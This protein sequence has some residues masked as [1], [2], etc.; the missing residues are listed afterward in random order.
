M[1]IKA[2]QNIPKNELVMDKIIIDKL[3][4]QFIGITFEE[5]VLNSDTIILNKKYNNYLDINFAIPTI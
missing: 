2:L 5:E 1:K 3:C 4:N